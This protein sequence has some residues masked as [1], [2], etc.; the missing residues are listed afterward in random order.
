MVHRRAA[1]PRPRAYL[2]GRL[3]VSPQ[4]EIKNQNLKILLL[5]LALPLLAACARQTP[6]PARPGG[7]AALGAA[8]DSL[9]A[10]Y[11][12]ATVAVAVRDPHTG[13]TLDR[14][15]LN[16][17]PFWNDESGDFRLTSIGY[18]PQKLLRNA[19]RILYGGKDRQLDPAHY[20]SCG[21]R[22]VS[23]KMQ[24]PFTLDGQLFDPHPDLP[25]I[26]SAEAEADFVRI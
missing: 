8:L 20:F 10:A 22:Q 14:L 12:G 13:T 18:P 5:V 19:W 16:S 11:P 26:L 21:A 3:P 9:A 6:A 2:V 23:L 17:R 15:V 25:L 7:E 1:S 24:C 4:S